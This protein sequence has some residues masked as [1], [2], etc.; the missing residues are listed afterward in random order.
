MN[1]IDRYVREVGKH[2][3]FVRGRKDIEKELRSTLEDMLED[4]TQKTGRTADEAIELELLKEYG[5]PG[6][7]AATYNPQPYL[8][9][10]RMFPFFLM[11][12]KIVTTVIAI[13]LLVLTGVKISTMSPMAGAQLAKAI[14]DGLLGIIS[15]VIAAFGNI[16]LVFAILERFVPAAEFKTDEEKEW[17]PA[18]LKKEP[19]PDEVKIWEPV[20]AIV[21]TFIALSIFNYN[22]Q[23]IGIY[24]FSGDKWSIIPALTEAFFR[25]LPW[26]NIGWIAEI[27]LNGILL[28]T[29]RWNMP[30]RV[31][32][33]GIK[34]FQIIIGF[35]LLTGP[36]IL[37]V[38]P[39]SL[40][41]S[42]IFDAN[43]A[44][45]L[46]TMAQTGVRALIGLI[47]FVTV[48]DAIK[49]V[50]KLITRSSSARA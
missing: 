7:V 45:T 4:R 44:Q 43:A 31:F 27:A 21:F 8:I 40:L 38:T 39:K 20:L 13:V 36:S 47:I 41:A 12:L 9:G 1:L 24:T 19:E 15:A 34:I 28:R 11:V 29:G 46:G 42:G 17:D 37:A 14:G 3:P 6:K 33:I 2:L 25:W 50:Y 30:T 48:I 32:S 22:P 35:F 18:S 10:P 16:V 23:W 49:A 5:E 26:I